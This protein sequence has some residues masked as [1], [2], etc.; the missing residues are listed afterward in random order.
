[1]TKF[2]S[3][4][5]NGESRRGFDISPLKHSTTIVGCNALFRDYNLEYVV[6]CDK[7]M[8]QEAANTVGKNTTIYTRSNWYKNFAYWPNVK[9]VPDLP[10]EGK[11]RA[12]E[13][14]HW[15]TGPY[16]GLVATMFKPKAIFMIGF[17]LYGLPNKGVNNVYK[18][19]TGYDYIK[20]AVDPSYWIH[21][22]NKLF[23]HTDCRWIVVNSKDWKMPESWAKNK[24]VFQESYEGLAKWCN[25]QLTNSK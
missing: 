16:A 4:I 17:D 25:K 18:N 20:S 10:Y 12:D 15:G 11:E 5:G 8:C 13:P 23:E 2:V 1:M 3:V 22:F 7:H 14:F 19:T 24:N 21:Q 9:C 6:C